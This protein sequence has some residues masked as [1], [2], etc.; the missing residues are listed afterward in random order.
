MK[1]KVRALTLPKGYNKKTQRQVGSY[2]AQL[3]DQ[4]A[5]LI[6]TVEGLTPRQL[7]WQPQRGINTVGMLLAHLAVVDVFWIVIAPNEIDTEEKAEKIMKKTIGIMSDDD[8]LPLKKDGVH[9]KTLKG[10]TLKQYLKMLAKG[11]AAV[12]K[13]LRTWKDSDLPRSYKRGDRK[14]THDWTLYHVLEHFA[15]H[16]GQILLL[17]HFMRDAK[18]LKAKK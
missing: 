9:P 3:D 1:V 13:E 18:V 12:H 4:L 2:A 15:A 14:I 5:R 17:Q 10:F 11:R 16:Y 6:K 8:G 7:E